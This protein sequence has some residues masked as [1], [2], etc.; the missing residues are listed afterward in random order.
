MNFDEITRRLADALLPDYWYFAAEKDGKCCER[1]RRLDGKVF[2]N[3]DPAMPGLP[4]HPNCHCSLR[5]ATHA[6]A[7]TAMIEVPVVNSIP[8]YAKE[9]LSTVVK[10]IKNIYEFKIPKP[11]RMTDNRANWLHMTWMWFFEQGEN[12]IRFAPDSPESLDIANSFSMKEVKREYFRTGKIPTKW[13][14]TGP[15]TATGNLEEVEW[16]IGTYEIRNFRLK[17][18]I[19]T[20]TVYN[21]SGWHSGTRLPKSWIDAIKEKT[22]YEILDL[23]TDAP[24]GKVIRTKIL[25]YF[26]GAWQIPGSAAILDKLPSFGGDWEQYYEI[27]MEWKE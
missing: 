7:L 8:A 20:F 10:N 5:K 4:L 25:K 24:R 13:K 1:C 18:G 16:F 22:S 3:G 12:P 2:R 19:A 17:D 27:R 26:P 9:N 6:E 15:K 21:K 11:P 14:F 23:V